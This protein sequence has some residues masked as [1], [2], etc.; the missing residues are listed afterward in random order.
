M[1]TLNE[2][3]Y[4]KQF[5][6]NGGEIDIETMNKEDLR[7]ASINWNQKLG[8]FGLWFNGDLLLTAKTMQPIINRLA[9]LNK[10]WELEIKLTQ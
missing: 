9:T 7:I 2:I 8:K 5:I 4:S 3:K 1:K 10:K 6:L